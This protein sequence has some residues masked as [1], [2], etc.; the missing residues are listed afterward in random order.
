MFKDKLFP[1]LT[2][3]LIRAGFENPTNIQHASIPKIKSGTNILC[4]APEKSGKTSNIVISTIQKLERELN[5]VPRAI[6]LVENDAKAIEM[7]EQFKILGTDTDLRFYCFNPKTP[8][9]RQK[10]TIYFGMDVV[11]GTA[12]QINDLFSVNALN[13]NDLKMLV[14]DDADLVIKT[15]RIVMINRI[16]TCLP[17]C[18]YILFA[19][20]E[21]D[22]ISRFIEKYMENSVIVEVK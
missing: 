3:A 15:E 18:Q 11:I 2:S 19:K 16:A 5:D 7:L 17:K 22:K 4:I 21:N 6:I 14:I 13:I 9:Q 1:N 12:K 10:E 20:T 8:I